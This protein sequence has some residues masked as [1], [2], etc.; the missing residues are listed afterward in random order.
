MMVTSLNFGG[1]LM[2]YFSRGVPGKA[3]A[4]VK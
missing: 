4:K 2:L 3:I 1:A